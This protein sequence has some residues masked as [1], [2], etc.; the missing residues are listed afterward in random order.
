M[1]SHSY[2]VY[3]LRCRDG[4]LY[5]GIARNVE[6]RLKQ[7]EAGSGSKYV[8]SRLPVRLVFTEGHPDRSSAQRREAEL[9][10]LSRSQKED[11]VQKKTP[12]Q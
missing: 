4:S 2:T 8:R 9:K 6:Q 1:P 10:S 7:H 5:T 3:M 11:L 12:D